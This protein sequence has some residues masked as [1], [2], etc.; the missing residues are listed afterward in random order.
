MSYYIWCESS[1]TLSAREAA[2]HPAHV[3]GTILS[4]ITGAARVADW[5]I[6][7]LSLGVY[8]LW[9]F[10]IPGIG[11]LLLHIL[12]RRQISTLFPQ[13]PARWV[14]AFATGF[15]AI[16]LL[17]L[18]LGTI[19]LIRIPLIP[20]TFVLAL[21]TLVLP[22]LR[23]QW[24]QLISAAHWHWQRL[25]GIGRAG[26]VLLALVT[27]V[28]AIPALLPPTQSDGVRYHLGAVQEYLKAG[29]IGYIQSN[30][31][32]NMPFLIEMHF[33]SALACLAEETAQLMHF[34][35]A[36][37][38]CAA[39]YTLSRTLYPTARRFTAFAPALLYLFTPMSAILATWPFTDHGISFFLIVSIYL[40]I[41]FSQTQRRAAAILLGV[42]LGAL[43]G[44]KYTMG[45]VAILILFSPFFMERSRQQILPIA[46][47]A[48]ITG[49]IGGVWYLKN[50]IFTGNPFYPLASTLF[51]GGEWTAECNRFLMERASAKGMGTTLLD[52][53]LLPWNATVHWIRFEAHNPGMIILASAI[54]LIAAVIHLPRSTQR[55]PIIV[56]LAIT[57]STI[58]IWFI[59]YQSNRLLLPT[60]AV[61]LALMPAGLFHT[62]LHGT[63]LVP[64]AP[65]LRGFIACGLI[66]FYGFSWAVQWSYVTTGLTPPPLPYLLGRQHRVSYLHQ[67]LSYAQAYEYLRK[68]VAPGEKALLI[69]EHRIY[70][71]RFPALWSD[72]FDTPI[73]AHILREN[74]LSTTDEL[75]I[76]LHSNNIPWIAINERE[77]L[78]QLEDSFKP[79]FSPEEW[80][81]FE[82][83]RTLDQ[84]GITRLTIPP[85]VTIIHL[86]DQP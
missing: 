34:T 80:Q 50:L 74:Q 55:K 66:A 29:K 38:N 25:P 76:W 4:Q 9:L 27:I 81:I 82:A 49:L 83:L 23:D 51:P 53:I 12:T 14:V 21:L 73:L 20:V 61:A 11:L 17:Q 32:S 60:I 31:Y 65:L 36:L 54:S 68:F 71:A 84:P 44:T 70:G 59:S 7:W 75:L 42:S 33:L 13:I 46:I 62:P 28:L 26:V 24:R 15:T 41:V 18:L 86:G 8:A 57:F 78:P 6:P 85:G 43:I 19:G 64:H 48:A 16:A 10:A 37:F 1:D 3:I 58:L 45:P 77:L 69:G 30:A 63:T 22:P 40:A 2:L 5:N 72:W 47:A 79:R 52:F 39:I 35:L 56:A 67:S